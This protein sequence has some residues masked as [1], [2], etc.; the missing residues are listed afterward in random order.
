LL[1]AHTEWPRRRT[2]EQ[3]DELATLGIAHSTF[4]QPS[5]SNQRPTSQELVCRM[6]KLPQTG[7]KSLG[8]S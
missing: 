5:N 1:R 8:Q 6:I 2:T 4:L 3:R 7:R